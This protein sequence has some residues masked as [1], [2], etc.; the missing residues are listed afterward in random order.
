MYINKLFYLII[1]VLL[2]STGCAQ[3]QLSEPTASIE[4]VQK[5]KTI[6]P[7]PLQVGDFVP[8]ETKESG[9]DT[10]VTIR[11]SALYSPVDKSFSLYLRELLIVELKTA[12]YLD[13]E[14]STIISGVLSE[15]YLNGAGIK[16]G[17]GKLGA[18]FKVLKNGQ[19]LYDKEVLVSHTWPSSFAGAVAIPA[20]ANEYNALYRKLITKLIEDDEFQAAI[21]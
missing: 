3:L 10:A 9:W 2:L 18:I 16:T 17:E 4:T 20:A 8:L 13:P 19:T 1:G 15:N 6:D 12:G 5:L 21:E 14:S 7:K 11:G